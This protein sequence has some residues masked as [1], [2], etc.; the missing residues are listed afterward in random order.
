MGRARCKSARNGWRYRLG[1][2]RALDQ[3]RRTHHLY[4][5]AASGQSHPLP[6]LREFTPASECQMSALWN[7]WLR[8]PILYLGLLSLLVALFVVDASRPPQQQVSAVLFAQSVHEYHQHLHPF[9]E[10]YIRCRYRPT[11]SHYAVEAVQKYGIAKGLVLAIRRISSCRQ[12]VPQ[13][14]FDPVP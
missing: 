2:T 12:S 14:T 6:Q 9:T 3:L 13:G 1:H 11:C 4:L 8:S 5:C 7:R 10:K